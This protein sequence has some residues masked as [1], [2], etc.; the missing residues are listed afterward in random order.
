MIATA[1]LLH[2]VAMTLSGSVKAKP[3]LLNLV[4]TDAH[5]VRLPCSWLMCS[6]YAAHRTSGSF[7]RTGSH[8]ASAATPSTEP[9]TGRGVGQ[10]F[11]EFG[12]DHTS[13][14][15]QESMKLEF[16]Q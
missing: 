15:P 12:P 5:V 4:T 9:T 11:E 1:R 16:S 2:N 6:A 10:M 7:D 13:S 3:T 14:F 8:R